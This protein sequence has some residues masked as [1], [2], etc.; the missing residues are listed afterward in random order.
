MWANSRAWQTSGTRA[1][2]SLIHN[3]IGF[4][5]VGD[6]FW[7][8][9]TELS[10][11]TIFG[12]LCLTK[13]DKDIWCWGFKWLK[14]SSTS[15]SCFQHISSPATVIHI[16]VAHFNPVL[17]RK[18]VAIKLSFAITS[19]LKCTF[20]SKRIMPILVFLSDMIGWFILVLNHIHSSKWKSLI[21]ELN[22]YVQSTCSI[23]S[24][25]KTYP[26]YFQ[27]FSEVTMVHFAWVDP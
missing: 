13:I 10:M 21:L 6:N 7:M 24:S 1:R 20:Y 2:W 17:R 4:M 3:W 16:D 9:G 19:V 27:H 26:T 5:D 22:S 14:S 12:Y 15:K 18:M 25:F 8:L 23:C 11:S